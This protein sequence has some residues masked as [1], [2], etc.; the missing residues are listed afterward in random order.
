[1]ITVNTDDFL[2]CKHS[3]SHTYTKS[4]ES[5]ICNICL[6][7]NIL[8]INTYLS[9]VVYTVAPYHD[10]SAA[11]DSYKYAVMYRYIVSH[12]IGF[13]RQLF[14]PMVYMMQCEPSPDIHYS[15]F[16]MNYTFFFFSL[17]IPVTSQLGPA[18]MRKRYPY[19]RPTHFTTTFVDQDRMLRRTMTDLHLQVGGSFRFSG[20]SGETSNYES[21][22]NN[23]IHVLETLLP[24]QLNQQ[25]SIF[26]SDEYIFTCPCMAP[27]LNA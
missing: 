5:I 19:P 15:V 22:D 2:C 13:F 9:D 12:K 24:Q 10:N 3:Y 17:V 25:L 21:V 14:K 8:F 11:F 16:K 27:Y 18:G 20:R 7:Y 26:R 6:Y 1:M 23:I 4:V